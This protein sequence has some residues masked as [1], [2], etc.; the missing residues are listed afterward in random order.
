LQRRS[1]LKK[2]L[3]GGVLLSLG[4]SGFLAIRKG[5]YTAV[6]PPKLHVLDIPSFAVLVAATKRIIKSVDADPQDV[7]RR[8]DIALSYSNPASQ[9]DFVLA[10]MLLENAFTGLL[11]RQR[12]SVFTELSGV[13]QDRA[14][15]GW[16]DSK[17]TVLRGAYHSIRRLCA[18]A[19]YSTLERGKAIGYQGPPFTPPDPGPIVDNQRLSP[20]YL[21]KD[22]RQDTGQNNPAIPGEPSV[23]ELATD[24]ADAGQH[25]A[26]AVQA[27]GSAP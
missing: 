6:P 20:P 26:P 27:G 24:I 22:P 8:I 15:M 18:A 13:E 7:A 23:Q 10:L 25:G 14:L 17:L 11:F 5:Q 9:K 4:G 3:F 21:P 12:T 1:F 19:H 16:R 2:G